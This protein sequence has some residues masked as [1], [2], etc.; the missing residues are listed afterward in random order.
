M[1]KMSDTGG[2]KRNSGVHHG[3]E[4][5]DKEGQARPVEHVGGE[6]GGGAEHHRDEADRKGWMG[7]V[8]TRCFLKSALGMWFNVAISCGLIGAVCGFT[9]D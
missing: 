7:G 9:G 2:G 5:D 6:A 1:E 8:S 3:E 4:R